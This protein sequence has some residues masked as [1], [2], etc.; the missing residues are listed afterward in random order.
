MSD[1][2]PVNYRLVDGKFKPQIR[3]R[4][5]VL[6]SND[7][8]DVLMEISWSELQDIKID[9]CYADGIWIYEDMENH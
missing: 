6:R 1:K 9:N 8:H 2:P 5:V 7:T 3:R 4:I